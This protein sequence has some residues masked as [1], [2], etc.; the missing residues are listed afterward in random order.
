MRRYENDGVSERES[1]RKH[2]IPPSVDI[3]EEEV[4]VRPHGEGI[5]LSVCRKRRIGRS[6]SRQL[7]LLRETCLLC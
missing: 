3:R 5:Y 1:A 7:S 6:F 2:L 4:W